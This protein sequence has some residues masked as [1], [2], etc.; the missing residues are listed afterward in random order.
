MDCVSSL[1]EVR[2]QRLFST[3]PDGLPGTGSASFAA[4]GRFCSDLSRP[5]QTHRLSP[6][7]REWITAGTGILLIVGLWTPLDRSAGGNRR[8]VDRL[9]A[10]QRFVDS[11]SI[12]SP[13]RRISDA[14]TWR[15]VD[16]CSPFRSEAHLRL[17]TGSYLHLP[18]KYCPR[19]HDLVDPGELHLGLCAAGTAPEIMAKETRSWRWESE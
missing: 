11:P 17:G 18:R 4:G 1:R 19:N 14:G 6:S 3:F 10:A 8:V 15:L 2:L 16:R 9:R 13:G 7:A 5:H 12:G